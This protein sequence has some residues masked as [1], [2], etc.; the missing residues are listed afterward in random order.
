MTV[1]STNTSSTAPL[2]RSAATV[3]YAVKIAHAHRYTPTACPA[4]PP[5]SFA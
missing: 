5:M 4:L 3:M 2:T 1:S